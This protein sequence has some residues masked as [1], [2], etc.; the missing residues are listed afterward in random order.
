[1]P[2][3]ALAEIQVLLLVLL[4]TI[5]AFWQVDRTAS[6]LLVPYAVWVAFASL[7][8]GAIWWLN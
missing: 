1:M 3:W 8:N 4:S 2:G 7:L 6:L 5:R